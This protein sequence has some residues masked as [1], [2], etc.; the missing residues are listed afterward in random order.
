M[1]EDITIVWIRD[2]VL[3]DRMPENAV[4][5]A[6]SSLQHIP[7]DLRGDICIEDLIN[8][9]FEKSGVSVAEKMRLFNVERQDVIENIDDAAAYY[10]MLSIGVESSLKYFDGSVELLRNLRQRGIRHYISSAVD[11]EV[12]DRW[13]ETAQGKVISDYLCEILGSRSGFQKG[14]DHFAYIQSQ[15][16]TK[17]YYIADAVSEIRTGNECR[18]C[19]VVPVGFAN[20]ITGKR[21]VEAFEKL[22][23]ATPGVDTTPL[24]PMEI[25]TID[26]DRLALPEVSKLE[27]GLI[28]AGARKIISSNKQNIMLNLKD[29]FVS[30]GIL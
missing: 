5:F 27:S 10:T 4:A 17:I 28:Q 30:D 9:G 2:G 16:A 19:G 14:R 12:L 26:S 6:L 8:W 11:Q 15:G 25:S 7:P 21:V 18:D 1:T 29:Y 24:Y 13:R 3:V 23:K 22:R 20:V